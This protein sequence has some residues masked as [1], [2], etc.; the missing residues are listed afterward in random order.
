MKRECIEL[1]LVVFHF[2]S[3]RL[4]NFLSMEPFGFTIF[5]CA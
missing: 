2:K 1:A 3:V 5:L 4:V